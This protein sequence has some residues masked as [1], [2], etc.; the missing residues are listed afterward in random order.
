MKILVVDDNAPYREAF[1]RAVLVEGHEVC[2]AADSQQA[3]ARVLS[4]SPDVVVTDLQMRED[5]EGLDL[6]EI[7]KAF[8]PLLPLIMISGVGS[9]EEGRWPRSWAQRMSF[10][11]AV[12]RTRWKG[13][14]SS[15]VRRLP[16]LRQLALDCLNELT[17]LGR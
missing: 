16:S 3:M 13:F 17:K 5:R 2:E 11:R 10:T 15:S 1:K 8:D 9:F 12:S 4:D 7:L 6:I 14:S